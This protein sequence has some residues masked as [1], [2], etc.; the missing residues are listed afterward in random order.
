MLTVK[1]NSYLID[2]ILEYVAAL[3]GDIY[4]FCPVKSQMRMAISG[5]T[6]FG[7]P[8]PAPPTPIIFA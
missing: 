1:V 4:F 2:Y 6:N 3:G 5:Y 8:L 7:P